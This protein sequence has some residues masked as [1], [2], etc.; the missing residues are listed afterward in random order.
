MRVF[1]FL[2]PKWRPPCGTGVLQVLQENK[3]VFL[4]IFTKWRPPHG[5]GALPVLQ[6]NKRVVLF[7]FPKWRPLRSTG[8][9][10]V[11]QEN[12][13]VFNSISKMA[14][15]TWRWDLWVLQ[16]HKS[17]LYFYFQNGSLHV[18]LGPFQSCKN[19]K[20]VY[21]STSKMAASKWHWGPSGNKD[22]FKISVGV[23]KTAGSVF[24]F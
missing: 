5:I 19:T 13:D 24:R 11:L 7:L 10:P 2:F 9:L 3:S 17:C 20:A 8:A 18:A 16:E 1:L 6:E 12:K 22:L 14:A 21:I 4:F 15:S 23:K